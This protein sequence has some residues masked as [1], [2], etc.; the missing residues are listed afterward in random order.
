MIDRKAR[1]QVADDARH[2]GDTVAARG[3]GRIASWAR[4]LPFLAAIGAATLLA[5]CDFASV[6]E[7]LPGRDA[8]QSVAEQPPAAEEATPAAKQATPAEV[9]AKIDKKSSRAM[10]LAAQKML[11]DLGYEPGPLDGVEGPK[12]R[13][14]IRKFEADNGHSLK[15][16]VSKALVAKLAT[17]IGNKPIPIDNPK[18]DGSVFPVYAPGDTFVY[19]DGQVD[20]VVE[21]DGDNIRWTTNRGV[22]FISHRNFI[23]PAASWQSAMRSEETTVDVASD[24]LWP[25]HVGES[26]SFTAT[27]VDSF[28]GRSDGHSG[29]K[30]SWRCTVDGTDTIT[31]AAGTFE[32]YRIACRIAAESPKLPKE[33]VWYFAPTI[34]HYVRRDDTYDTSKL[35]QRVELVAIRLGGEG[36]PPAARAGLGWALQHTLESE[37]KGKSIKWESSG[38]ESKVT[39][40]P[41]AA[42]R[43]DESS[44]CRTFEQTIVRENN[45][46]VYPGVACRESSGQWLIPGLDDSAEVPPTPKNGAASTG[47]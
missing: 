17:A 41:T 33:R 10:V 40:R 14:A 16:K 34:G 15:G 7:R 12:T 37:S 6:I 22:T 18:L 21:I 36:W 44:Y 28:A 42:R 43:V 26:A 11:A 45:R 46:R 13:S 38:V 19:S 20:T 32:S 39:I 27:T 5:A 1:A 4:R 47:G 35:A 24:I 3:C 25:L 29:T 8:P 30:Q 2:G 23:L 9:D 31:V